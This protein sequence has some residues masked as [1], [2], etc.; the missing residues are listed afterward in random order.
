MARRAHQKPIRVRAL[1]FQCL[2]KS[3]QMR[4]E[5]RWSQSLGY[6]RERLV[7]ASGVEGLNK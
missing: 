5:T 6:T 2:E 7:E 3:P 1:A 4:L